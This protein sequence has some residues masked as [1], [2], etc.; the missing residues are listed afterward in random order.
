M[1]MMITTTTSITTTS[2]MTTHKVLSVNVAA[3]SDETPA[4][5]SVTFCSGVVQGSELSLKV[6]NVIVASFLYPL[7]PIHPSI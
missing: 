3:C 7:P 6:N 2:K 1:V 4:D 5:V